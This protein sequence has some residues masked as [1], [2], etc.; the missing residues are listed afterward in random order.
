MAIL[1]PAAKAATGKE[2]SF[3]ILLASAF[4]LNIGNKI[5]E[6]VL[7]LMMY[8]ITHSSVAMASMR[9]AELLPNLLFGMLIGVVVDRVNKKRWVL[10]M[11]AVQACLLLS[12]VGLAQAGIPFLP[13]YYLIGFL[14]MTFNYGY[15]NAQISLTKLCVPSDR[16]TAANAKLTFAETFVGIMGP[17]VSSLVLLLAHIHDGLLITAGLYVISLFLMRTLK[18]QEPVPLAPHGSFIADL[19]EGWTMFRANRMLVMMTV[20]VVL[21]NCTMTVVNT[22]MIFYAKDELHLSSSALA[23]TLSSA[24]AGGLLGSICAKRLRDSMGLGKLFGASFIG[25]GLSFLGLYASNGPLLMIPA[26][27]LGGFATAVYTVSVYTFRLEQ[28]PAPLMGRIGGIT[29][30]LFRLGMPVTVYA[31]GWVMMWWGSS[32]IFLTAAILNALFFLGYW[33]TALWRIR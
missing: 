15:F 30:T 4:L 21:L 6:L 3:A 19:R 2:R 26:L 7:P 23:L 1:V 27:I 13:V 20:F 32:V 11:I 29:G 18:V 17:A 9:T 14:L 12:L 33:K 16:L 25:N 28:T 8:D 24:G 22:T 10:L 5:Y 31:A